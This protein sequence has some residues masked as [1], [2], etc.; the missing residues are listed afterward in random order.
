M[1]VEVINK[2]EHGLPEY[3]T[4]GSAGLDIKANITEDIILMPMERKLISTG[5]YLAIP[6]GYEGHVRARSGLAL[7]HG[8]ALIDGLGTIDSD[9]RGEL[10]ILVINLGEEDFVMHPGD[11]IAQ[12]VLNKCEKVEFVL[13]DK[14]NDTIRGS[15]GYGHTGV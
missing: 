14:L 11:R 5:L 8:I 4:S 3:K 13:V 2:G 9:Y 12:F 15:G 1:K 7:N 10:G 6:E